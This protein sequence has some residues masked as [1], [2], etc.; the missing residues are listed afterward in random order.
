MAENIC[1]YRAMSYELT[2]HHCWIMSESGPDRA[3]CFS[4]MTT[5]PPTPPSFAAPPTSSAITIVRWPFLACCVRL[6][7]VYSHD[8]HDIARI[9]L[10]ARCH[11]GPGGWQLASAFVQSYDACGRLLAMG[12][13][14]LVPVMTDWLDVLAMTSFVQW[15]ARS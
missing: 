11:P 5:R 12:D 14:W 13:S 1:R 8:L 6:A 2:S 4:A 3:S 10:G 15:E 7:R 9:G